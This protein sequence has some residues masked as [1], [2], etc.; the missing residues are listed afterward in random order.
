MIEERSREKYY[1][2]VLVVW[3]F[4]FTMVY[5]FF[6]ITTAPPSGDRIFNS[7]DENANYIFTKTFAQENSFSIPE[8][9]NAIYG[10]ILF[11]RSMN[12]AK[13]GSLVPGSFFGIIAIYGFLAKFFGKWII[14]FLTPTLS[15]IG[16]L[17]FFKL[18]N[19]IFSKKIALIST[20]LLFILPPWWYYNSRS[21][22]H[23]IL[24]LDLFIFFLY[25]F[26]KL[27]VR[28]KNIYLII[29][30]IFLGLAL[31]VRF[32]EIIWILPLFFIF[33]FFLKKK[34]TWKKIIGIVTLLA[35]LVY[36]IIFFNTI[37]YRAPFTAGYSVE[38]VV[39]PF[40]FHPKRILINFYNY[41]PSLFWWYFYPALAGLIL[42]IRKFI[43]LSHEQKFYVVAFLSVSFILITYYGSWSISD[44]LD[45]AKVT[46]GT[47]Y[48]RYWLFIYV[49]SL[50]FIA[51]GF[52]KILSQIRKAEAK[53]FFI[54]AIAVILGYLSY[55][56][57]WLKTDESFMA[58]QERIQ[59]YY[60][61]RETVSKIIPDDSIIMTERSDKIF[62]P[63][64]KVITQTMNERA[65]AKIKNIISSDIPVYY[66]TFL[67]DDDVELYGNFI[68]KFGIRLD[69][70]EKIFGNE[71]LYRVLAQ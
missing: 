26:H 65:L 33:I 69:S 36:V 30:A 38:N 52:Q 8:P 56:I 14:V 42:M 58:T 10:G 71:Y 46:M 17:C 61:K 47:S 68:K 64:Y 40:G 2:G 19:D 43:R 34:F 18:L 51:Y 50:P 15:Y 31:A 24:F 29:S 35:A 59:E 41:F 45:P 70:R 3:G 66:Y 27:Y 12:V 4:F 32:S 23:N 28:K 60:I 54:A 1:F 21:M 44:N 48:V 11:P 22:F 63:R 37:I 39:F 13:D 16:A 62:F 20:L 67:S 53:F 49:F 57:V 5:G 55:R 6:I 7:P 25:S 9:L